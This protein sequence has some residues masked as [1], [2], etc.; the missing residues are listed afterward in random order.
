MTQACSL[1]SF[2]SKT[3]SAGPIREG[4]LGKKLVL[5]SLSEAWKEKPT[6]PYDNEGQMI[7]ET[8]DILKICCLIH[9]H[10]INVQGR[11]NSL[12]A[13]SEEFFGLKKRPIF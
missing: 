10:N 13:F 2:C 5:T 7:C 12:L 6:L 9:K 11:K 3:V 8:I 4:D 1:Y